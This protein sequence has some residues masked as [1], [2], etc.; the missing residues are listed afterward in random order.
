MARPRGWTILG[1]ACSLAASLLITAV[2]DSLH[3]TGGTTGYSY[4]Y[5]GATTLVALV[6][7]LGP[8][9]L[10]ALLSTVLIDYFFVQPVGTFTM[11]SP[12]DIQNLVLFLVAALVVGFLADTRRRQQRQSADLA[13]SLRQA[14]IALERRTLEAEEGRRSA[15]ELARVSARVEAL[16]EADR[17]KSELLANVSHQLRTP[18]GSIVGMSSALLEPGGEENEGRRQYLEAIQAE[19]RHLA[20]LVDGL[21]EMSRLE[22]GAVEVRLEPLDGREALESAAARA[23]HLMPEL[24]VKVG[25]APGLVEADDGALQEALANLIDNASRYSATV[26]LRGVRAGEEVR[27]E[28]ADRGPG[29]PEAERDAVFE[30]FYQGRGNGDAG[31]AAGTGLGLA[32]TRRLVEA[33]GG[34]VWCESRP[35]GGSIFVVALRLLPPA[36]GAVPGTPG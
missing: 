24:A 11:S 34:R 8:A 19:G 22:A 4:L 1:Y 12:T 9:V 26:E 16:A 27:F 23:R 7:G 30:R 28:V 3:P 17:L 15:T 2:L 5:L 36:D 6:F 18:L 10:S 13:E 25:G 21:L 32:I 33:M 31:A 14:N 35:G 20:R 29:V